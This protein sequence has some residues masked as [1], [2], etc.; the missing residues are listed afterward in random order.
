MPRLHTRCNILLRY[1][2]FQMKRRNGLRNETLNWIFTIDVAYI[3]PWAQ[4]KHFILY[5]KQECK[6][7]HKDG[8]IKKHFFA[9]KLKTICPP[10]EAQQRMGDATGQRPKA[11][12]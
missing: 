4:E 6:D 1:C 11:Q 3:R 9:G 10:T 12:K 5:A 8:R 2:H 7:C